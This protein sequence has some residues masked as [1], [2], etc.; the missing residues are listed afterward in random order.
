MLIYIPPDKKRSPIIIES[1]SLWL[2]AIKT[3]KKE[4]KNVPI[5]W[6]KNGKEK[7]Q[8]LSLELF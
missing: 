4:A 8:H 3:H 5:A 6:A 1:F 7:T 2:K